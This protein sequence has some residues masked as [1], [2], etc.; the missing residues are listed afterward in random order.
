MGQMKR[1]FCVLDIVVGKI[2]YQSS[3]ERG[4]VRE[5]R[6]FILSKDPA[7]FLTGMGNFLFDDFRMFP[8]D[9]LVMVR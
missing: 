2:A 3:C 5:F 7:D 9:P 1:G 8:V 6:A 4:K